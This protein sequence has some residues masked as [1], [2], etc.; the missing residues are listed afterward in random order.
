MIKSMTGFGQSE[1]KDEEKTVIVELRS[2]NNKYLK[3]NLRIPDILSGVE[4]KIEKL[5]KKELVEGL[6]T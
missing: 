2:V 5:L 1:L 3:I 4:D 6:S